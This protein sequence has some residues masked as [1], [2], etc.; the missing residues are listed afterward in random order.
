[1]NEPTG[2]TSTTTGLSLA[3]RAYRR[4][5]EHLEDCRAC[6]TVD[7]PCSTGDRLRR[8]AQEDGCR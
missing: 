4:L 2:S 7:T 8:I 3:E 6:H 5:R 1:M